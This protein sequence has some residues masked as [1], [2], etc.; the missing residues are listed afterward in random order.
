M[1]IFSSRPRP[2]S[3]SLGTLPATSDRWKEA[4]EATLRVN[5]IA[6]SAVP[7]PHAVRAVVRVAVDLLRAGQGSIMLL[8]DKGRTLAMSASWGLPPEAN[9]V[10]LPVGESIAGRVLATGKPLLLNQVDGEAFFN[11]VTKL[12]P[13]KSSIV[14]PLLVQGEA[15]GVLSLAGPPDRANFTDTDLRV[16]QMFADQAAGLIHRV[17]LHQGAEQRSADLLALVD[18]SKGLLGTLDVDAL[19]QSMLDGGARLAGGVDGFVGL[20]DSEAQSMQRGVFRGIDKATI[21][22]IVVHPSVASAIERVD[23]TKV[24]RPDGS[25]LIAVGLCSS[26]GTKGVLVITSGRDRVSEKTD[27]LRAFGQQCSSAIGSA[28]MHSIVER[29]E[30]ELSSIIRAVPHP[31]VLVDD[32]GLIVAINAAAEEVFKVTTLHAGSRITRSSLGHPEI[33]ELLSG[34]GELQREIMI[35]SPLRT[36]KARVTD[37]QVSGRGKGRVLIMDDVTSDRENAQRQ[38][39]FVAMVGHELRTPLTIVKGFARTLMRRIG[40]A[41]AEEANEALTTI[42]DK[43][44]QLE[45]LIEDLLYVSKIEAREASLRIEQV[46]ITNLT[47][48]VVNDVIREYPKRDV[49]IEAE[50]SVVWP[51]D[52][53]K[54]SLVMRHLIENALKYSEEP[55]SVTIRVA[56]DEEELRIDVIDKGMGLVSSDIPHIFERFRQLDSSSTRRHGGTGVGLY[57]SAQLVRV[58]GGTITVDSIWGKGSTFTFTIPRRST[59]KVV[60]INGATARLTA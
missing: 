9:D 22:E 41:S 27:L 20:L 28:E 25:F 16:A 13:L 38:R 58:H 43:A 5:E 39:D 48:T 57:L 17:R 55:E 45:R 15:I 52:E 7:L 51:C 54:I 14:V 30:S 53:T 12:R 40:S 46:D 47:N 24:E 33:E 29:K 11:F 21:G 60:H 10:K 50:S 18:A 59:K 8:E 19:L 23:A 42:D 37:V 56:D 26:R 49:F 31:I 4:F 44:H 3:D 32:D 36:F 34:T 6:S 1:G 2:D 35:G